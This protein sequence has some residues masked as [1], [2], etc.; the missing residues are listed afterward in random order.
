MNDPKGHFVATL[1]ALLNAEATF[2]PQPES[3]PKTYGPWGKV[4]EVCVTRIVATVPLARAF[5]QPKS[6]RVST[7]GAIRARYHGSPRRVLF[8]ATSI[9]LSQDARCTASEGESNRRSCLAPEYQRGTTG[10]QTAKPSLIA[11]TAVRLSPNA[12]LPTEP[13][14][15]A[16]T[17]NIMRAL[18]APRAG[19]Y[20][21]ILCLALLVPTLKAQSGTYASSAE[22]QGML[23]ELRTPAP[24]PIYL[25]TGQRPLPDDS[26][27][28]KVQNTRTTLNLKTQSTQ[29]TIDRQ[30]AT[31]TLLNLQTHASW[32]FSLPDQTAAITNITRQQNNWTIPLGNTTLILQL[33]TAGMA[34][35]TIARPTPAMAQSPQAIHIAGTDPCFGLGERF[36]QAALSNTHFDV[37]PADRSGEPGHNW[38]YVAVPLVYTPTGLG[39]YADTVFDT[40]F[41]FNA[42]GSAFDLRIANTPVTLYFLSVPN[43]KAILEQY[44]ALTGRPENPPLWTFGPWITAL[45]GRD[46]VLEEAQ[47]IRTEG[48]PASA[49]WVFDE[50]DEPNNLGWPFWFSSYY[51]DPR[52]FNDILHAQGYK[53]LGY[54]HPYLRER[55]LPYPTPS[56][57]YARAVAEKLL[58][59][60][61]DGLPHGP[62]FEPVRTG[63][64][65]FTNPRTVDWWQEMLTH[66]ARDQAWDGWMEDFG[67]Y[68]DDSDHLAAGDGTSLSELYP[69][70]YHKITSRIVLALNPNIVSFA[71]SGFVG[72]QQFPMLWGGD[73][74][75]DWKRDTGLPSVITAGIT[76][77]MSAYSTWGPDIISDGYDRELWLRW[78]EFGALTP[79]MRDHPWSRPRFS[80]DLWHDPGTIALFR[81]Y[82]ILH[83]SLLPYFATYAAEAHRTGVPILRHLVLE[84]PDD[85]RAATAEYQYLLGE[86]LLV[87]PVIE[88]GAVTRKLYLPKGDW[89]N[90]WTGD[91][92]TGG[93][94]VTVAAPLEQIPLFV[95][96]GSILPFKPEMETATLN[97]GDPNLLAGSLVWRAYPGN[98]S[99]T[100]TF[101]LPDRTTATL[102]TSQTNLTISGTSP[103]ERPYEVVITTIAAPATVQLDGRPLP[104]ERWTYDPI[105]HQLHATF[106]A[107]GFT[108]VLTH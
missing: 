59:T 45:Q 73:Q 84:Y 103:T 76:A 67:E 97:W 88:Q 38:S 25:A 40:K 83:T 5:A 1:R 49:L 100:S 81:R 36:Y 20:L 105:T 30:A 17:L 85:P 35:I 82:A 94:D 8:K 12:T 21:S 75:H 55:M 51:G 107:K 80:V 39:L 24:S 44:T 18:L 66:A 56:P 9:N 19:R 61:I 58:V 29:I 23:E 96:A 92:L 13:Y 28:V 86:S 106:T 41:N 34:R 90:Y 102:Q 89:L 37:R 3:F 60:G 42:A 48:I 79:V 53:V 68:V 11:P 46:A 14:P 65:D 27:K 95:R 50:L 31:L 2:P 74:S 93:T 104:S 7:A 54:V 32:L 77:G 10:D 62:M 101:T 71:R 15:P 99:N 33:M 26:L 43:P 78:A 63:N 91:H 108:L 47:R 22:Y 52:A 6:A 87:A 64:L 57:T 70:L 72:T 69:L 16:C 98:A 4:V